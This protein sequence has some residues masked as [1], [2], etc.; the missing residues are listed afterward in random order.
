[1]AQRVLVIEDEASSREALE[2]L[3]QEEGYV[4]RSASNG[5]SAL[6]CYAEFLPDTVVCDYYLPD[7]DGL[8]VM[9]IIRAIDNR[10]VRFIMVSAGMSDAADE[11]AL[12]SE[13]DVYLRKPID[14]A[15][16]AQ[17]LDPA[18]PATTAR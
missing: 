9:R 11:R 16:L 8:G 4:V 15:E 10:P 6:L 5:K 12:H 1:M 13:V 7:L 18:A 3:L 14:L 17:A 2:S